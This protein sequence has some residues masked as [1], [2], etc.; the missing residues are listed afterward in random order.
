[1]VDAS[2]ASNVLNYSIV[3]AE[4]NKKFGTR[5]DVVTRMRT[6]TPSADAAGRY[7]LTTRKKLIPEGTFSSRVTGIKDTFGRLLDGDRDSNPGGR[8]GVDHQGWF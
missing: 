5:D 4:G 8:H 3:S 6:A 7:Q 1:M 2:T